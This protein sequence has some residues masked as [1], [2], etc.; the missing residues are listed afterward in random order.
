MQDPMLGILSLDT[1][2]PRILGDVGNPDSYPFAAQVTV[3]AGADVQKVVRD[4]VVEAVLLQGFTD[5]A[6]ALEAQ[7]A[8]AIVSTCG[9][10]ITAQAHVASAVSVPVMLSALSMYPVVRAATQGRIGIL[11]AS[12][13]AFGPRAMAAAGIVPEDV[14]VQ[15]L[16]HDPLFAQTFLAA[17]DRQLTEFDRADME[18]AVVLAAQALQAGAPDITAILMECGNLPPYADAVRV[19]T[20]LPVYHLLDG[21]AWMMAANGAR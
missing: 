21:A 16:A 8:R 9:F 5:A 20:K 4:G 19:A 3:V 18:Y 13:V 15:G 10:L 12:D 2:F 14:V 11:T 6:R 7:G 1:T 17:R